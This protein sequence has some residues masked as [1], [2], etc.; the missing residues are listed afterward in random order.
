MS[1]STYSLPALPYAYNVCPIFPA[2]P[3]CVPLLTWALPGLPYAYD[4]RRNERPIFIFK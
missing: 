1:A 4:V 3:V 2:Y